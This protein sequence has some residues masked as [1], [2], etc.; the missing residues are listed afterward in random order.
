M[1][2]PYDAIIATAR[3]EH[4]P[5]FFAAQVHYQHDATTAFSVS[6]ASHQG[7]EMVHLHTI[8]NKSLTQVINEAR[9]RCEWDNGRLEID[10]ELL[11]EEVVSCRST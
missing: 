9:R 8:K 11:T 10:P 2:V 5:S 4:V 7:D 6:W 3:E 1:S